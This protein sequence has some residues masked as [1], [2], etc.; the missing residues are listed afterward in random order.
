[1][2]HSYK[3]LD[4][5]KENKVTDEPKDKNG[6]QVWLAKVPLRKNLVSFEKEWGK[7][8]PIR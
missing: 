6:M 5:S 2:C 1:M 4:E 3:A 8:T 7:S